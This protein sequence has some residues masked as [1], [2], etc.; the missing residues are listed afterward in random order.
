MSLHNWSRRLLSA[1][2]EIVG[3][4]V[5][6][7]LLSQVPASNRADFNGCLLFATF[8]RVSSSRHRGDRT[9]A[10]SPTFDRPEC[11]TLFQQIPAGC[12]HGLQGLWS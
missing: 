7:K 4:T 10:A 11:F 2:G 5:S 9:V 8:R 6:K 1:R 3:Q 12:D